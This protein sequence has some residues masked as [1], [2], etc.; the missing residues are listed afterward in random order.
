MVPTL[1]WIV[2]AGA[3]LP[4]QNLLLAAMCRDELGQIMVFDT[5]NG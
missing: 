4:L 1:V 5:I 2:A 3:L